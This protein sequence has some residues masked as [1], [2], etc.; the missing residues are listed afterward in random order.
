MYLGIPTNDYVKTTR[1][2]LPHASSRLSFVSVK[3]E[4]KPACAT[5]AWKRMPRT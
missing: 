3:L 4:P 5:F 1:Y 2:Q